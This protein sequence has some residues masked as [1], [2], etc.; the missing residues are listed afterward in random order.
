M[1]AK[2]NVAVTTRNSDWTPWSDAKEY[3]YYTLTF[4]TLEEAIEQ[5]QRLIKPWE[6]YGQKW[7]AKMHTWQQMGM[8][9]WALVERGAL[10]VQIDVWPTPAY[11]DTDLPF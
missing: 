11:D 5:A 2:F 10:T 7:G 6:E 1:D 9:T 3:F 4:D 8:T